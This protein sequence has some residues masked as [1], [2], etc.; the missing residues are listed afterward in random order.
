MAS[1][2]AAVVS[3]ATTAASMVASGAATAMKIEE[4]IADYAAEINRQE[5]MRDARLSQMSASAGRT[6]EIGIES[7]GE[8]AEQAKYESETAMMKATMASSTETAKIGA[9]GVKARGSALMAAQQTTDIA[10][11]AADRTAEAGAAGIRIAGLQL[12]NQ[13]QS[14]A[15]ERSLLTLEYKQGLA[16]Q[17]RKKDEL[18]KNKWAMIAISLAGGAGALGTSFYN[19]SKAFSGTSAAA[20]PYAGN[21][22]GGGSPIS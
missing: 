20:N 14:A 16:E 10:Y 2:V 18:E 15:G 12:G 3:V 9:S 21:L 19:A 17:Q 22:A 4:G 13:L 6:K 5:E 1:E 7:I 8:G 11:A